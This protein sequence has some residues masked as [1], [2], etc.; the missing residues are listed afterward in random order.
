MEATSDS[1]DNQNFEVWN[2][3]ETCQGA[4]RLMIEVEVLELA[5]DY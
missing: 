2:S 5:T 1:I 3:L 4:L